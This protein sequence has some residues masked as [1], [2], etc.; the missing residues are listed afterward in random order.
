MIS[1]IKRVGRLKTSELFFTYAGQKERQY[2]TEIFCLRIKEKEPGKLHQYIY[3][4]M[5][6]MTK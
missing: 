3:N 1:V 4:G 2:L 5:D 6:C